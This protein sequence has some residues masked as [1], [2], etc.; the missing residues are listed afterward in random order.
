M[1]YLTLTADGFERLWWP[2]GVMPY[3]FYN[4]SRQEE[5]HL[6]RTIKYINQELKGCIKIR[7]KIRSDKNWAKF[8][9]VERGCSATLGVNSTLRLGRCI[10]MKGPVVHEITHALGRIHEQNRPDRDDHIRIAW[11]NMKNP[12]KCIYFNKKKW[13]LTHD[14]PYDYRSIMHYGAGFCSKSWGKNTV[15]PLVSK[16]KKNHQKLYDVFWCGLF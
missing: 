12:E 5:K 2:D 11:E 4:F 3:Q 16:F 1:P 6:K 8:R 9:K 14:V 7:P 15:I 13:P 10:P